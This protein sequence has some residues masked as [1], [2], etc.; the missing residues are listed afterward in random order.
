[1]TLSIR[2]N[3]VWM[4]LHREPSESRLECLLIRV[5]GR[6]EQ[7]VE[8]FCEPKVIISF[9]NR[10]REVEGDDGGV[11][12]FVVADVARSSAL[13][14]LIAGASYETVIETE[15]I[16][17]DQLRQQLVCCE[18][19]DRLWGGGRTEGRKDQPMKEKRADIANVAQCLGVGGGSG[20]VEGGIR[21]AE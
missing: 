5:D 8:V 15:G 14:H 10:V 4:V 3:L 9:V 11:S 13:G 2:A 21:T 20:R 19:E 16:A 12:A 1:M 18:I 7:C 6:S 17:G